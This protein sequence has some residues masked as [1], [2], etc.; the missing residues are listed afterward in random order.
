VRKSRKLNAPANLAIF[1]ARLQRNPIFVVC[2]F[3][4]ADVRHLRPVDNVLARPGAVMGYIVAQED[5]RA[6]IRKSSGSAW[7]FGGRRKGRR[8]W[9]H[10]ENR[11]NGSAFR[12]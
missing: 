8:G 9:R 11:Q 6:F 5:T 7:V 3:C 4:E 1:L 12:K 2:P 10:F